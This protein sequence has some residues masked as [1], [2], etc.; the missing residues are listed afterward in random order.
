MFGVNF[1]YNKDLR[2]ILTEYGFNGYPLRKDF[3]VFGFVELFY[4]RKKRELV[5]DSV[6]LTQEYRSFTFEDFSPLFES[7]YAK[8]SHKVSVLSTADEFAVI[9]YTTFL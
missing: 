2:R 9:K 8:L 3:P 7:S 4:D 6:V 5:Y 1:L